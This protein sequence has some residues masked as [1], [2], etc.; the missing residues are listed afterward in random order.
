MEKAAAQEKELAWKRHLHGKDK[1]AEKT[2]ARKRL[3]VKIVWL[4]TEDR[5]IQILV[6]SSHK[7]KPGENEK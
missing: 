7:A 3:A 6:P 4:P 5:P 2:I 1:R